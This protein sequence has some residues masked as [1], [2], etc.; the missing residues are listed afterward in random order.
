MAVF[1][2]RGVADRDRAC[3]SEPIRLLARLSCRLSAGPG[4]EALRRTVSATLHF[5]VTSRAP[6]ILEVAVT[7]VDAGPD[8]SGG[9]RRR[10]LGRVAGLW[11]FPVKSMGPEGLREVHVSWHGL[12]GDR[13][14][15]FIRDGQ[16]RS[17]TPW[18]TISRRPGMVRYQ[19][20]FVEPDRPDTSSTM[21]RTPSGETF[22]VVDPALANELGNGI[23]VIK[24]DR[25]IFDAMPLSV[26]TTQSVAGV[27]T[28][29]GTELDVLRFRPNLVI[30]AADRTAFPEDAWVGRVLRV[31][32]MRMRVDAR[33]QRCAVVNVNPATAVRDPTV[34]RAIA[35]HRQVSLGVYGT[36][37]EPGH[38]AVGDSVHIDG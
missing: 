21:V 14:W 22:D 36:T 17:G 20:W 9:E 34:L 11:R 27:S 38:I 28:L 7:V 35:R 13:R 31:G 10:L 25:G 5:G 23:R 30:D 37:V 24:Q 1:A 32:R 29:V 26:I 15:A 8:E 2:T 19:P 3:E 12:A 33:D 4:G 18:L 16:V 6:P